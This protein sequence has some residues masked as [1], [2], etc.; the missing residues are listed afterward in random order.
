MS[1]KKR[2]KKEI[3]QNISKLK[4]VNSKA[5]IADAGAAGMGVV[6]GGFALSALGATTTTILGVTVAS[7]A[8]PVAVVAGGAVLGGAAL[9]GAKRVLVDGTREQGKKAEMLRQEES[10]LKDLVAEERRGNITQDDK[11][12][13]RKFLGSPIQ[14]GLISTEDAQ[15]LMNLVEDGRIEISEAYELVKD[16]L[17]E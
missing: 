4:R 2:S 5:F 11:H 12:Q 3:L 14:K 8:A 7:A 6:G 9:V 16:I 15:N 17:E 10:K 1:K 13:F